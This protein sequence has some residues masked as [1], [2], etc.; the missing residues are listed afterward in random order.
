MNPKCK[1]KKCI[2]LNKLLYTQAFS[3]SV[4]QKQF[5]QVQVNVFPG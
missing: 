3:S 5:L 1:E 4:S 2:D